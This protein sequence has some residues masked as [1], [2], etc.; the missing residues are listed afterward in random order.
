MNELEMQL[1]YP[2]GDTLAPGGGTL[3]VA[4]GVRW[5][6]MA[7]PFALN[8]I[9]LWQLRD[10][11]DGAEGWSIV[12]CCI[13]RDEAKAQWESIFANELQGLPILRVVVTHMHPDHIGLA[14]WLC[15]RWSG[16]GAG[17]PQAAASPLGG[18]R[19]GEGASVGARE[20]RLWISAT[21][22]QIA[23]LGCM[24]PTGFGGD[25]AAKYFASHGLNSPEAVEQIKART[26]YFPSLVPSVPPS[27]RRLMDGM[28]LTI[29]GRTWRCISG[30]GHAPEH[31]ALYCDELKVLIGGDM[32][33]PRISTN[34]S[35]YEQEPEADSLKLFLDSIDKF[36]S[37][38]EGT[39]VLP[40]H[41]KPFTG[42]HTRIQQLHDHHRDRLAEVMDACAG[43]PCSAADILPVLFKRPMDLHQTTFAMGE[44]VAHLHA[45]WFA[46]K[47]QRTLGADGV[48]RFGVASG[49]PA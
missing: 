36:R 45:L 1:H 37:L 48:Y 19:S 34:V 43:H 17:P 39:L 27:Y 21:D 14:H 13:H 7:L 23:R 16:R 46:G 40:S 35:V 41:G 18:Q 32:M 31:I 29:G 25:R 24:G 42:L 2:L 47:L 11:V 44:S 38:P 4:S 15:E 12:D 6:R 26:G 33:L 5:I 3:E 49:V 10:C 30:Y 20:C 28:L 22:Y 8:H 9:N